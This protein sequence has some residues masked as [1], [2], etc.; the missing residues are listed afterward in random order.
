LDYG[1]GFGWDLQPSCKEFAVNR[2]F[3]LV[4][5]SAAC[6]TGPARAATL[7]HLQVYRDPG[8]GCC[9]GWVEHMRAAGFT[10][11]IVDDPGRAERR[12]SLGVGDEFA[13]CHTAVIDGYVLE[14]H[15]PAADIQRLLVEKPEGAL[16]LVVPGMPMGSPG[17]GSAGPPFKTLLLMKSGNRQIFA[18]H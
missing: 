6:L 14:G 12:R 7:P 13:S 15:V 5:I 18:S 9:E 16:G 4:S 3:L 10:A 2:R 8:C 17:M 1:C 11:G